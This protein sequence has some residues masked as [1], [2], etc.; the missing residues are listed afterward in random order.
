MFLSVLGA[1]TT[2]REALALFGI[3]GCIRRY[4]GTELTE[5]AS[6]LRSKTQLSDV[7]WLFL[8]RFA[9]ETISSRVRRQLKATGFPTL[10]WFGAVCRDRA[11]RAF[12]IALAVEVRRDRIL[13]LDPLGRSPAN[14]PYN[15]CIRQPL[16]DARLL[17]VD[18]SF[19]EVDPA[20]GAG[21]LHWR[22]PR[23]H[24]SR[25]TVAAASSPSRPRA[26]HHRFRRAR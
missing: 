26:G 14:V 23:R 16:N 19:Y 6:I 10:L 21:I 18:G 11:V 17:E 13:L 1:R 12:H 20:M 25:A 5:L 4:T 24:A 8:K 7:R 15:V 22:R 2:R 3:D 9:F